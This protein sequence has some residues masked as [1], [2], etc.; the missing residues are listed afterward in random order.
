[1][2]T[3]KFVDK[4]I[5]DKWRD[6]EAI[7]VTIKGERIISFKTP[8]SKKYNSESSH[9][10]G[11]KQSERFTPQ[12]LLFRMKCKK[13]KLGLVVDFTNTF[14]YY[15]HQEFSNRGILYQK[16]KCIG[17][18]IPS[19]DV[20]T[21]FKTEACRFLANDTTGSLIGVHCTHGLN[22]SGYIVCRYLIECR[23]YTPE[24]AIE[25]FSKARGYPMERE[26]YLEDLKT[27]TPKVEDMS[28]IHKEKRSKNRSSSNRP[29]SSYNS[30]QFPHAPRGEGFERMDRGYS[31]R[32]IHHFKGD[33]NK[34]FK[35]GHSSDN[36]YGLSDFVH[37]LQNTDNTPS[38]FPAREN[39][40]NSCYF[41]NGADNDNYVPPHNNYDNVYS[42][43]MYGYNRHNYYTNDA[44]SRSKNKGKG[45]GRHNLVA[46]STHFRDRPVP[47]KR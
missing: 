40:N 35:R 6:Y 3:M 27:R 9:D 23:G 39:R 15:D 22:R 41:K 4:K 32:Q 26:N 5:P 37:R 21:R 45:S 34:S 19:E 1:M 29:S 11:I 36:R 43:Y 28:S 24:R 17:R 47:Y 30:V 16:I 46:R 25:A 13:Q 31:T 2:T 10:N 7:G 20:V 38:R 12:D 33:K 42:E 8:L 44:N 14:R 18:Q